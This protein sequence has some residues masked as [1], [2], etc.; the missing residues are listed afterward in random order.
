MPQAGRIVVMIFFNRHYTGSV[1]MNVDKE[2]YVCM[3]YLL[4]TQ[5][6][7]KTSIFT[8]QWNFRK[9]IALQLYSTVISALWV[10]FSWTCICFAK[11]INLNLIPVEKN[12]IYFKLYFLRIVFCIVGCW[13]WKILVLMEA[14]ALEGIYSVQFLCNIR[15]LE[16]IFKRLCCC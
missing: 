8:N 16:W 6:K 1:G 14:S 9:S 3:C 5:F 4:L 2:S 13:R 7:K 15:I 10:F 12:S 11:Q